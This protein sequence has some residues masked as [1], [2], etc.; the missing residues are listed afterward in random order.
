MFLEI[1]KALNGLSP[2]NPYQNLDVELV[3]RWE[4]AQAA[5][6]RCNMLSSAHAAEEMGC[7]FLCLELGRE[8]LQQHLQR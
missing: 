3:A 6:H 7:C 4:P 1:S 8:S 5:D 2:S